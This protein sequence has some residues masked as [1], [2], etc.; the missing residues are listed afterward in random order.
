MDAGNS[1]CGCGWDSCGLVDESLKIGAYDELSVDL[2]ISL[3]PGPFVACSG[4]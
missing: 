2:L 3:S 4:D 1:D